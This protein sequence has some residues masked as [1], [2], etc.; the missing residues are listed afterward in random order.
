[1]GR[2]PADDL[3]F[4]ARAA[5]LDSRRLGDALAPRTTAMAIYEGEDVGR[6]L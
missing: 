4:A 3:H 6:A 1:M 2:V 5:G